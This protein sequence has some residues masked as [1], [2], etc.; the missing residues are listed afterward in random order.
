M[1][2]PPPSPDSIVL[3]TGAASGIGAELARQLAAREYNLLLVDRHGERLEQVAGELGA[4]KGV[5][6][7]A[8]VCD[9]SVDRQRRAL[10]KALG[11][12]RAL[13]GLCNNAGIFSF[14]RFH[15]LPY[16]REAEMVRVNAVAVHHLTGALLPEMVRRGE[17]AVLN[18]ASLAANQPLPSAATYAAT[19]AFV[20]A[21]SEALHA[22]LAGSG[23]S[24]TSLCPGAT[25][26]DIRHSPG[27][28]DAAEALPE[29]LWAKAEDVARAGI[30]GMLKGRR[31]VV[32]GVGN[33]LLLGPLGRHVPRGLGLPLAQAV[34]TRGLALR[35]R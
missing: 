20:H 29:F 21:F 12:E 35:R 17:G 19:K 3:V 23:V 15:E 10:T 18:T 5:E 7:D 30:Q 6:V 33:R 11:E 34:S 25:A 26:T 16:E 2:L 1:S 22:E 4:E 28:D 31:T 14:G 24:C 8:H 13:V 32:P 27:L 9:L